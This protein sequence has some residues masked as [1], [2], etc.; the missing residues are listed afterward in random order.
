MDKALA[1]RRDTLRAP[2][3]LLAG[4]LTLSSAGVH[5]VVTPAHFQ[6]WSGYGLFFL[7]VASLQILYALG[8]VVSE[9]RLARS[10][11]YLVAGILG[12]LLVIEVYALSRTVGIPFLGPH[13][14]HVEEIGTIDVFSKVLELGL[15]ATL[16]AMLFRL[17]GFKPSFGTG[18][19]LATA[20]FLSLSLALVLAGISTQEAHEHESFELFTQPEPSL[21]SEAPT[22]PQTSIQAHPA[23]KDLL[24]VLTRGGNGPGTSDVDMVYAPPLLFQVTGQKLPASSVQRPT[25][26]FMMVEADHQHDVGLDPEPPQVFLR[27]D[28]GERIE[29]YEVTVLST[30]GFVHRNSWLLFPLPAGTDSVVWNKEQHTLDLVMPLGASGT[31]VFSW[32]LPLGLPGG[33]DQSASAPAVEAPASATTQRVQGTAGQ[34]V[35]TSLVETARFPVSALSRRLSKTR[36]DIEYRGRKGIRVEATYATPEYFR[37]ALPTEAASRYLPDRFTVFALSETLHTA[38]LPDEPLAVSFRL[39]GRQYE[40][41]LVE[42]VTTSSHHR[43]TLLRFPVEPPAGLRHR[44]MELQLPGGADLTWHLPISYA[45]IGSGSGAF[46]WGSLLAVLAGMVAAMWPCLFQLT[47]FFIPS[48]AGLGMTE[49]RGSIAI[50]TRVQVV[51][52]AFFFVLGFTLVYT[53]AGG[54]LG[55]AAGKLGDVP[56]FARWQRYLGIGGGVMI[57]LLALRVAAKVRAPLVCKMPVLSGMG[58]SRKASTPLEMMLAGLAFATGCMTCFGAALVVAMVVY[59]GLSGSA[60]F[61]AFTLFMFSLGMGIPLILAAA[62]MAKILPL[63]SRMEKAVRWMGLA[64]SLVMVGFAALLITGNYMT[65]TEWVYRVTPGL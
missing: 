35:T 23:L 4:L 61:G 18:A 38:T 36:G 56:D 57:I 16:A 6:E 50:P 39:D 21:S 62:V 22:Q 26:T 59:V 9:E 15:V 11:W 43:V 7:V 33:A 58:H 10:S 63:L 13:A 20:G 19:K 12:S 55:Y 27:L 48:L 60:A 25:I 31:S 64:S 3:V 30:D 45:G 34:S 49:V 40:P 5:L 44:V 14:G 41:D 28:G 24:P 1:P 65:L 29:P 32:E 47:V 51:K 52:A 54:L 53:A 17:P 2:L 37:S 8:L 46:T 42:P